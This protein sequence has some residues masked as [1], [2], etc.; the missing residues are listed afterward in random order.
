MEDDA[1]FLEMKRIVKDADMYEENM[2]RQDI[3]SICK[4]I[5]QSKEEDESR[6]LDET[7][8]LPSPKNNDEEKSPSFLGQKSPFTPKTWS[9]S[10]SSAESAT[11][12]EDDSDDSTNSS[13][14]AT[15]FVFGFNDMPTTSTMKSLRFITH[16]LKFMPIQS[17]PIFLKS[18]NL[19]KAKML[20]SYH[21]KVNKLKAALARSSFFAAPLPNPISDQY[22]STSLDDTEFD[23]T[24]ISRSG[25]QTK[26]KVYCDQSEDSLDATSVKKTKNFDEQEWI[27]KTKSSKKSENT[28]IEEGTLSTEETKPA[29]KPDSQKSSRARKLTNT[30]IIQR[31]SL[32]KDSP[33]K[34]TRNDKLFDQL[35]EEEVKRKEQEKT[36]ESFRKTLD[37]LDEELEKMDEDIEV[38]SVDDE[39]PVR[40]RV[41]PPPVIMGRKPISGRRKKPNGVAPLDITP[42]KGN[43]SKK[44]PSSSQEFAES[45]GPPPLRKKP[46]TNKKA[47]QEINLNVDSFLGSGSSSRINPAANSVL[48][49]LCGV[50]FPEKK[51]EEHAATCGDEPIATRSS[52]KHTRI[53]CEICDAVI[54]LTT[55]YE[56]HVKECINRRMKED[57]SNQK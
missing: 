49:P 48:C 25:R 57:M 20:Y 44:S 19:K 42:S 39:E 3:E 10:K 16:E 31:S 27:C 14:D 55:N 28:T 17:T 8:E 26:R 1:D 34:L 15:K 30:D 46:S 22:F 41:P 47:Q 51:I 40:R 18:D 52:Q 5:N 53:S 29:S 36:L 13:E 7:R 2:S 43:T 45:S 21:T 37:G 33:P 6:R 24:Y 23:E 38:I 32:F 4:V 35:K 50:Y 11:I 9:L 54:P 56:V 12:D